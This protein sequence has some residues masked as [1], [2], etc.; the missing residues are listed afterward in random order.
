MR[1]TARRTAVIDRSRPCE[2]YMA[3][4][5]VIESRHFS[6]L[7]L[8]RGFWC[9]SCDLFP[10]RLTLHASCEPPFSSQSWFPGSAE[11]VACAR[12]EN[13]V[14]AA[15]MTLSVGMS[16]SIDLLDSELPRYRYRRVGSTLQRASGRLEIRVEYVEYRG[17][18]S[19]AQVSCQVLPLEVL[20]NCYKPES[21]IN[22]FCCY[23]V[24]VLIPRHL[25]KTKHLH[26]VTAS[27]CE[28]GQEIMSHYRPCRLER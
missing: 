16:A 7:L 12:M 19:S 8:L 15:R 18:A 21:L 4:A 23:R 5:E 20:G 2:W 3:A 9:P 25:F 6:H 17:L 26:C 27:H 14:C 22:P 13:A 24:T 1:T 10:R 11:S 28:V